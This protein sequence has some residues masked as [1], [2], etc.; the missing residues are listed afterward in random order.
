[1]VLFAHA[2]SDTA[3]RSTMRKL[4]CAF[5]ETPSKRARLRALSGFSQLKKGQMDHV[6]LVLF[7]SHDT[8]NKYATS[9]P[10]LLDSLA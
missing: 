9:R 1:V 3:L 2:V 8:D 4:G 7:N 6:G 5:T 10:F